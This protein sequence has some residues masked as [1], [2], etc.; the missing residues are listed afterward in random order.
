MQSLFG[1]K[2]NELRYYWF[3]EFELDGMP[4]IISRTGWSS[5]LGYEI[6]LRDGTRGDELWERLM[7]VGA[8]FGQTL[9][10][11]ASD[12]PIVRHREYHH[13]NKSHNPTHLTNQC[14]RL[15]EAYRPIQTHQTSSSAAH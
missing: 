11:H 6:Y 7:H 12:A 4:L 2:I 14:G 15:L 3:G 8:E 13:V 10:R 5:E 1:D 9:R